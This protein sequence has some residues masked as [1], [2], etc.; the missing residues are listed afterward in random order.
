MNS[1]TLISNIEE[2][3]SSMMNDDIYYMDEAILK[4]MIKHKE[5]LM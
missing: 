2:F 3:F 1:E 5:V 4:N